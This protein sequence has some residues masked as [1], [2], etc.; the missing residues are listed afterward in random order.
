MAKVNA[1]F[2]IGD[3]NRI[4][5]KKMRGKR[6]LFRASYGYFEIDLHERWKSFFALVE[7]R[8]RPYSLFT[9]VFPELRRRS[10]RSRRRREGVKGKEGMR[11]GMVGVGG[12]REGGGGVVKVITTLA[13]CRCFAVK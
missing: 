9:K 7:T 4:K 13:T 5:E 2:I 8:L 1:N 11:G 6:E 10:R 3:D 12:G